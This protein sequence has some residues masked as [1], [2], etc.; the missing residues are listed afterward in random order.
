MRR[1]L[2]AALS[3]LSG[4]S[5][6]LAAIMIH[7]SV[8]WGFS[9][10]MK[11]EASV[12]L[13]FARAGIEAA[14]ASYLEA[15]DAQTPRAAYPRITLV[16]AD[17]EVLF[18]NE[19]EPGRMENH[20]DR[21]EIIAAREGRTGESTRFSSTLEKNIYYRAALLD[22]GSVLRVA[23]S[24]DSAA[25]SALALLPL[26]LAVVFG[27]FICAV[28]I[29]SRI[30]SRIVS[31][32]NALNLEAP[33]E[34]SVYEELS[35]LLLRIKA[36]KDQIKAQLEELRKQRLEA[37]AI[38]DSMREGLLLLDAE[39]RII[40]CNKSALRLLGIEA[41]VTEN[42]SVLALRRD[43]PF[44]AALDAVLAGRPAECVLQAGTSCLRLLA[45]PV[46]DGERLQGAAMLLLDV[47]EQEDRE[48]LRREF[49]ANVSHELK[50]PLTVISGYAE[51]LRDGLAKPEDTGDFGGKIYD[52][53]R[54]LLHLIN[55]IMQ[56]SRLD[57]GGEDLERCPVSLLSVVNAVVERAAPLARSR[58]IA[59]TVDGEDAIISGVPHVL[60]EMAFNLLENAIKYNSDGGAVTVSVRRS[61]DAAR[62]CVADTGSGIP[63][64]ERERVFERFYRLEKS[65][66][67]G[68]TGRGLS[69]GKHGARLHNAVVELEGNS[70]QGTRITLVFPAAG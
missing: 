55:D 57:E 19:A 66:A 1:I 18:D 44:R 27:A 31:P 50:T 59:V 60:Q 42:R 20:A 21:P 13:G 48:R 41:P 70:P 9:Q 23:V 53:A 39:G 68:G 62:L 35:P 69:I 67:G 16:A 10:R 22:D 56:L 34:N 63:P 15:L 64:A 38:T 30:T 40:S 2:L 33:E 6:V 51:I 7:F 61:A 49:S 65:R 43:E 26:I 54:R 46:T 58:N 25:A 14:G 11:E 52:E 45:S 29:A 4:F 32:I 17:G 37:G 36:Q 47:T 8:Y 3:L 28:I 24:A 5:I 12:E